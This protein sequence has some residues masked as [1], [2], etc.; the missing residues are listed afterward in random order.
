MRDLLVD[1][2][3]V[4]ETDAAT[5]AALNAFLYHGLY[6]EEAIKRGRVKRECAQ[7][8]REFRTR[9]LEAKLAREEAPHRMAVNRNSI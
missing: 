1:E 4:R 8:D 6:K 3:N 9:V 5:Q 7:Y 2:F